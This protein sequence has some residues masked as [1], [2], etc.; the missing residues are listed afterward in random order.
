MT[1]FYMKYNTWLKWIKKARNYFYINLESQQPS[2]IFQGYFPFNPFSATS[3]FLYPLKT[4]ENLGFS[5]A[6]RGYRKKPV[7]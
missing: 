2:Y 7:V 3:L 6:F 4:S 1:R 5:N